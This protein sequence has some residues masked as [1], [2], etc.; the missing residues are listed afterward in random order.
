MIFGW[1]LALLLAAAAPPAPPPPAA[2]TVRYVVLFQDKVSGHQTVVR[3]SD[4]VTRVEYTY[5]DNGRGPELVEEFT[6][7]PN[8]TFRTYRVRG[9]STF[10]AP[11]DETFEIAARRA[12]WKTTADSGSQAASG[13]ALYTP[14]NGSF[15]AV[16][17][18][19][20]ALAARPDGKLRLIP[21]GTLTM[22]RLA[23]TV[24]TLGATKQPLRLVAITGLG[25][26]PT[27]AWVTAGSRPRLFA[28]ISPG[29][30]R[31]IRHGW[32]RHGAAL[33]ARQLRAEEE[34][35]RGMERRLSH[36]LADATVVRDTRVFDSERATLGPPSDVYLYRG[37]RGS[38]RW[39]RPEAGCCCRDC[40]TCTPTS[41]PGT[42]ACTWRRAS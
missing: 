33:E 15:E 14:L 34:A 27:L 23:D 13:T 8:G 17:V 5:K 25:Y 31:L 24:L 1:N 7:A 16:S 12:R 21:G 42:A 26:A 18:S 11:V 41:A 35:L 3:G 38:S 9:T 19:V 40:S 32:Q 6:L 30:I 39:S 28:F 22:R 37:R 20:A 29:W 2:D 36:P 10:G 4:G